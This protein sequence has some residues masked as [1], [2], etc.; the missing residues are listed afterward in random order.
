[1]ESSFSHPKLIGVDLPGGC[2]GFARHRADPVVVPGEA[3]VVPE[4]AAPELPVVP[5]VPAVFELP[6]V[7]PVELL[8]LPSDQGCHN[9]SK[10]MTMIAATS[11]AIIPLPIPLRLPVPVVDE[12]PMSSLIS[13]SFARRASWDRQ[14]RLMLRRSYRLHQ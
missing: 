3:P 2:A 14:T 9:A 6:L 1:M 4:G 8:A 5:P 7:R 12:F 13:I 10:A 11:V